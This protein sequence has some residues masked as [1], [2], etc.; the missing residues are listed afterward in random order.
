LP[1]RRKIASS[2]YIEQLVFSWNTDQVGRH[3]RSVENVSQ[4]F[5]RGGPALVRLVGNGNIELR[6]GFTS[7]HIRVLR[8]GTKLRQGR[9]GLRL[10][11][12]LAG[13]HGRRLKIR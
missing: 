13:E 3:R 7:S 5:Q 10:Q 1:G 11:I 6:T 2:E 8:V 12:G 4:N 9:R